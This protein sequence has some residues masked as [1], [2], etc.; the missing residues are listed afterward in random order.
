MV[1]SLKVG[2]AEDHLHRLATEGWQ[3][4]TCVTSPPYYGL[5][6]YGVEGQIGLEE[7]P[8]GYVTKLVQV[9]EG[10]KRVLRDDGTLWIVIGDSYARQA[11]DDSKKV[12]D[13]GFD[14]G[15]SG[16]TGKHLYRAGNNK[17]PAGL[18]PK[19]LIGIPWM[20]AFALRDAG[21]YLRQEIIWAKGISGPTYRGGACMPE[22]V[23]DRCTKAHETIFLLSKQERYFFDY[24]AVK[25]PA[26]TGDVRSPNGRGQSSVGGRAGRGAREGGLKVSDPAGRNRRSVWH[27]NPRAFKGAHFAT[28]PQDLIR[29]M[30]LAGA[31][32]GGVVLDPFAGSGTTGLVANEHR[33]S[34]IGIELNPEYVCNIAGKRLGLPRQVWLFDD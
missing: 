28:F 8:Q 30:V 5:R 12:T 17:P 25:E 20:L 26:I 2:D 15:G 31:P 22:S 27:V 6:D 34:F 4:H 11:G 23:K 10:V 18:K 13:S 33:R 29:P 24:E 3:A 21:W 9:F 16:R 14:G 19:D 1:W 7:T 32:D